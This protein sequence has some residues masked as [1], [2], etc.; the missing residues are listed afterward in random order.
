MASIGLAPGLACTPA[1]RLQSEPMERI[2][3]NLTTRADASAAHCYQRSDPVKI[4]TKIVIDMASMEVVDEESYDYH[5]P[6]ARCD[7][8]DSGSSSGSTGGGLGS[9]VGI[10]PDPGTSLGSEHEGAYGGGVQGAGTGLGGGLGS[11]HEAAYG[12]SS[13]AAGAPGFGADV[14]T[15]LGAFEGTTLGSEHEAAY[16][17]EP[18][19]S[20]GAV[21][22]D[23]AK[24][25]SLG[26]TFGG[27]P[28]ALVGAAAVGL[29]SAGSRGMLGS[30][31][32]QTGAAAIGGGGTSASAGASAA[33]SDTG[34]EVG[35]GGTAP[36]AS[37]ATE[38]ARVLAAPA[39]TATP[40]LV[41]G[42]QTQPGTFKETLGRGAAG[43]PG[44]LL[45]GG[46]G[47]T[48]RPRVRRR[49]LL[50]A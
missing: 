6:V 16:G 4:Y 15:G 31:S 11:E 19:S 21:F 2:G 8:G 34:G 32:G 17:A 46:R 39:R 18:Q 27:W 5:G 29:A 1:R 24:G 38:G 47:V 14:S 23:V 9:D 33:G 49:T 13:P 37:G 25:F 35:G 41:E 22:A 3:Q 30:G 45:T 7:G 50:A 26:L 12:S 20:L 36:A 28:G 44:V 48:T 43:R 40:A 10:G 42:V